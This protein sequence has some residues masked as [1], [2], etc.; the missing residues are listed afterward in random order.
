MTEQILF[1]RYW[2]NNVE[3]VD[4]STSLTESHH[5]EAD[6][7]GWFLDSWTLRRTGGCIG[8]ETISYRGTVDWGYRGFFDPFGTRF[9]NQHVNNITANGRTGVA[10]C[11]MTITWRDSIVGWRK[12][13]ICTT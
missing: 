5:L 13:F 7:Q 1:L 9:H 4:T 12:E 3:I 6:G 10:T 2:W 8:C 11:S